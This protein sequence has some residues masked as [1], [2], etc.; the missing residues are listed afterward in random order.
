LSKRLQFAAKGKRASHFEGAILFLPNAEPVKN[1]KAGFRIQISI[2]SAFLESLDP[3]FFESQD[4][5][6][7]PDPPFFDSMDLDLDLDPNFFFYFIQIQI[8]IRIR[9][10]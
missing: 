7:D 8:R 5:A 4:L 9:N 10:Y 3:D 6:L 1:Q 2:W